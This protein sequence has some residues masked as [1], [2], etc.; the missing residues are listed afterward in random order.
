[1]G[2]FTPTF[3]EVFE[4]NR[5][6]LGMFS[7]DRDPLSASVSS[8]ASNLQGRFTPTEGLGQP[9]QRGESPYDMQAAFSTRRG[10]LVGP[11]F[12][13]AAF[14]KN[15]FDPAFRW[16]KP[17]LNSKKIDSPTREGIC[18]GKRSA[19]VLK[20]LEEDERVENPVETRL[21][22]RVKRRRVLLM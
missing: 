1:M 17:N 15:G 7:E 2:L 6:L 8:C 18:L 10:V 5:D 3:E 9:F 16:N 20:E 14:Q 12:T 13:S 21:I 4:A 19:E 11:G 22:R